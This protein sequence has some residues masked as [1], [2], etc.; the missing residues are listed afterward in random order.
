[1]HISKMINK[2]SLTNSI[3]YLTK[4]HLHNIF[5]FK[6]SIIGMVKNMILNKKYQKHIQKKNSQEDLSLKNM[7]TIAEI[8]CIEWD[9]MKHVC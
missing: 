3:Y 4:H 1:M 5:F 8:K 2:K 7:K 6:N 9:P